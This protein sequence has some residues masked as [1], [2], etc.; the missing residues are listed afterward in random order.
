[1]NNKHEVI[2]RAMVDKTFREALF[3]DAKV[4][5]DTA[6]LPLADHEYKQIKSFDRDSFENAVAELGGEA[7]G[8]G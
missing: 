1:M 3:K 7:G 2:G 8:A 6:G 5:C 4:A